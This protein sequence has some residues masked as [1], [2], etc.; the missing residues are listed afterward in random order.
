MSST[1]FFFRVFCSYGAL[2][3]SLGKVVKTPEVMRVYI[4]SFWNKP[5]QND[6]NKALFLAE[7]NDLLRDLRT[8]P[9]NSAVRKI[10]EL[11][12]R[13][14]S[15]KV[16]ALL[17]SHFKKKMPAIFYKQSAQEAIIKNLLNEFKE[18]KRQYRLPPGDFP[19]IKKFG[20]QLKDHD[21]DSFAK[22]NES[23]I[24]KIDDMLS[25]DIPRLM[26]QIAPPQQLEVDNNPFAEPGP[27]DWQILGYEKEQY[28]ATFLTLNPVN[29]KVTGA[30]CKQIFLDSGVSAG[31]L[32]RIWDLADMDK[33]GRL[34]CFEF[35][36]AMHLTNQ[37]K[38]T[39]TVPDSL[40]EGL[41]PPSLRAEAGTGG[42]P[43][44][45]ATRK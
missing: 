43:A 14:R 21:F 33:D 32:R 1:L 19:D 26:Q 4:G 5:Y 2:M 30:A 37:A 15:A 28:D 31:L 17:L 35:A 10:N 40:P 18:V 22:L 38:E 25:V 20:E 24:K 27:D 45:A 42:Q 23:L 34:D 8:L 29:G 13:C 3:W 7:Q 16:H 11:V 44:G 9:R 41:I 12:K 6:E 39:G 36:I